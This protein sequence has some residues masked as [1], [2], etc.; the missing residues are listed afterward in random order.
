M[1]KK[2]SEKLK[3]KARKAEKAILAGKVVKSAK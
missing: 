1:R 3:V 2:R